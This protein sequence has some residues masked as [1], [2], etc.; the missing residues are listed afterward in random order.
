MDFITNNVM[1]EVDLRDCL[2]T[3]SLTSIKM[4]AKNTNKINELVKAYNNLIKEFNYIYKVNLKTITWEQIELLVNSGYFRDITDSKALQGVNTK[5]ES[6]YK[7][8]VKVIMLEKNLTTTQALNYIIEQINGGVGQEIHFSSGTFEIDGTP[9][10]P[11]TKE[12]KLTGTGNTTLNFTTENTIIY[13]GDILKEVHGYLKFGVEISN[14]MFEGNYNTTT[15]LEFN[16]VGRATIN[17]CLFMHIKGIALNFTH[18][19][20]FYISNC[21]IRYCGNGSTPAIQFNEYTTTNSNMNVNDLKFVGCTFEH[22][23]GTF[24]KSVGNNNNSINFTACKLEYATGGTPCSTAPIIFENAS[25]IDFSNCR[26]THYEVANTP[27]MYFTNC[28]AIKIQGSCFNTSEPFAIAKFEKC[29]NCHVVVDGR[30]C[31][32]IV[33]V[34]STNLKVDITDNEQTVFRYFL[35]DE[36]ENTNLPLENYVYTYNGN[37]L[38]NNVIETSATANSRIIYTGITRRNLAIGGIR[39]RVTIDSRGRTGDNVIV[40]LKSG[41]EEKNVRILTLKEGINTYNIDIE[42]E[43]LYPDE[44]KIVIANKEPYSYYILALSY[45]NKLY[46]YNTPPMSVTY[47]QDGQICWNSSTGEGRYLGWIFNKALQKWLPFG[48]IEKTT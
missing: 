38:T 29:N 48:K 27:F 41:N 23:K 36:N 8:D 10:I 11:I 32:N 7:W 31:G 13:K 18:S 19:Q 42:G 25:R 9:I 30:K 44:N 45:E 20:D 43:K 24:I 1:Q 47:Y 4:N 28:F 6:I 22:C 3:E 37:K 26:F 21:Y 14:I 2:D 39:V 5:V 46:G 16:G 34:N 40:A 33:N 35:E 17:N 12:C 15:C